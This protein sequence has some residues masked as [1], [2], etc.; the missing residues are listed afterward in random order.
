MSTS[1]KL[2]A[3][4]RDS[5]VVA[6]E[7]RGEPRFAQVIRATTAAL[8]QIVAVVEAAERVD[9]EHGSAEAL[10]VALVALEKALA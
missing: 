6:W 1:E 10:H 4:E 5:H 3:L 8:P 7:Y 2:K 9:A